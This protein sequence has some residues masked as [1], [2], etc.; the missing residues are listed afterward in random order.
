MKPIFIVVCFLFVSF[1]GV[2]QNSEVLMSMNPTGVIQNEYDTIYTLGITIP[3]TIAAENRYVTFYL[4]G[5]YTDYFPEGVIIGSIDSIT[6]TRGQLMRIEEYPT[7]YQLTIDDIHADTYI[8]RLE[9]I[10]NGV[11][12]IIETNIFEHLNQ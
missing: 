3:K 1:F 7:K 11:Q 6:T 10:E 12:E 5:D 4:I 8:V 9:V 2:S